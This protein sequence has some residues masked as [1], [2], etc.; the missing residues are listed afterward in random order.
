MEVSA[1]DKVTLHT[2]TF[3]SSNGT[4]PVD[5]THFT[6]T[7]T[8]PGEVLI[9][10]ARG[11]VQGGDAASVHDMAGRMERKAANAPAKKAAKAP[12]KK[13]AAKKTTGRKS[14]A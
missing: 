12:G 14:S 11:E 9:P 7:V 10:W 6:A 8:A 13:S 2:T 5:G 1:G 4:Y 3:R